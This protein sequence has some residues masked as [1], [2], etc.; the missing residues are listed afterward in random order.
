MCG[1]SFNGF[2]RAI[3]AHVYAPTT[4]ASGA[5]SGQRCRARDLLRVHTDGNGVVRAR[6]DA[7]DI[8][9]RQEPIGGRSVSQAEAQADARSNALSAFIW[10]VQIGLVA[11]IVARFLLPGANNLH[12]FILT[13][14]LGIVGTL[15]ATWIG[16]SIGWYRPEQ[17]AGFVGATVG[18]IIVL[19]IWR[20][21]AVQRVVSDPGLSRSNSPPPRP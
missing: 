2:V 5:S 19:V 14:A 3:G 16:Q 21:L 13:A 17:G 9:R 4:V 11:G 7:G 15:V 20:R 8:I 6:A 1:S 18:A 10:I 12:G